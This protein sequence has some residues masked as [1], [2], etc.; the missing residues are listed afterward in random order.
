LAEQSHVLKINV[1]IDEA[2]K[3]TALIDKT[4]DA[5]QANQSYKSY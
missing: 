3:L 5:R 1:E 4:I 2:D